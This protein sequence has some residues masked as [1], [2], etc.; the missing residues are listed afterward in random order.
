IR[1]RRVVII[2]AAKATVGGS[3]N[4][5]IRAADRPYDGV[6]RACDVADRMALYLRTLGYFWPDRARILILLVL[7]GCG[8]LVGLVQVWPMIVL[9]DSVVANTPHSGWIHN[10]VLAWLPDRHPAQ[11]IA[12]AS[13]E[14]VL[15]LVQEVL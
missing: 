12:L 13:M 9:V 6:G 11:I 8:T 1:S 10:L 5:V 15:R 3:S 14:L 4:L 2:I 7:I